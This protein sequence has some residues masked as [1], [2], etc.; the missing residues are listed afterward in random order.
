MEKKWGAHY[1]LRETVEW[2]QNADMQYFKME[3][4]N[5]FMCNFKIPFLSLNLNRNSVN[6]RQ[7]QFLRNLCDTIKF[8]EEAKCALHIFCT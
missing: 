5:N 6:N 8:F 4:S 7:I 1:F 3:F 2:Q